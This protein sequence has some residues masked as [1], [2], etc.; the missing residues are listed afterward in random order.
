MRIIKNNAL[1]RYKSEYSALETENGM[2]N[3][4]SVD[5]LMMRQ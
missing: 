3:N 4:T 5:G 2:V 1:P